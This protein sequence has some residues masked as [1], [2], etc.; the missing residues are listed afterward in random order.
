MA[1][2]VV[3][4]QYGPMRREDVP[5]IRTAP[6]MSTTRR[7]V[8]MA[9][10][11]VLLVAAIVWFALA[12]LVRREDTLPADPA[13]AA[14]R[15]AQAWMAQDLEAIEAVL[16]RP[17]GTALREAI[18]AFDQLD[19]GPLRVTVGDVTTSED[20][21][22]TVALL[23][24]LDLPGV[25]TWAWTTQ[26]QLQRSRDVWRVAFGPESLHP[27]LEVELSFAV[28]IQPAARSPIL[29][30]D[31]T[32]LS[33]S[34]DA[35]TIGVHPSEVPSV[36]RLAEALASLVPEAVAPLEKLFARPDLE[37][38]WF[39]PLRTVPEGR[40]AGIHDRVASLPG[41][42]LRTATGRLAAAPGSARHLLGSV[43]PASADQAKQRGVAVGTPI[44]LGGLEELFDARLRH[45][46]ATEIV[47]IER[48]GDQRAV[49]ATFSDEVADPVQV[50]LDPLVQQA[51][52]NALVGRSELA[53]V[54][55]VAPDGAIL[56]SAARPLTGYNRAFEGAY[57]PGAA[58][59]PVTL[60]AAVASGVD[61]DD[62]VAC[63]ASTRVG[64]Q[65]FDNATGLDL[66]DVLVIDA[67]ASGCR[68]SFAQ[69][70]GKL[71]R[72]ALQDL[73]VRF[74][75]GLAPTGLRTWATP[76]WPPARDV[77]ELAAAGV[78]QA[79][80]LAPV[81]HL[82]SVAAAFVDGRWELPW[83]LPEDREVQVQVDALPFGPLDEAK[84]IL[85]A[86][87]RV[88]DLPN[89][90]GMVAG[91]GSSA[92]GDLAWASLVL[93][94]MGVVVLVEQD[95][96][97]AAVAIAKRFVAELATLRSSAGDG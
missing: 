84:A 11:G 69:L 19:A 40:L 36:E 57:A 60:L 42:L 5:V 94:D 92:E 47:T 85:Q 25:G 30:A 58:V 82:A 53:A 35:V 7:D 54:V 26:L 28:R 70:A 64:G 17:G 20:G 8:S 1:P 31:G 66:G 37:T 10:L 6:A 13:E 74:G 15:F 72:P 48:D 68:T 21:A 97:A 46:E 38:D 41:V 32:P 16:V 95:D 23:P 18:A 2:S 22:A 88:A 96:R 77:G 14:E 79:L 52:E 63:P 45:D 56:G 50:S 65:R 4:Q 76:Q 75:F 39:H 44:G 3:R 93:P 27:A 71:D 86:A 24:E 80:L 43:V 73:V 78:G 33:Q 67:V 87:G 49:V 55:A 62:T 83:L 81:V 9:M 29:Y 51:I 34:G 61:G 59:W 90:V 91:E 89:G 12:T